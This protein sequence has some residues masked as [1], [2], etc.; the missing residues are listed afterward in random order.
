MTDANSLL[1]LVGLRLIDFKSFVDERVELEAPLTFL[2][3]GN[4]S[5]KSNFLDAL[6]FLK[7]VAIGLPVE[8]VLAGSSAVNWPGLRGGIEEAAR[9]GRPE[10]SIESRWELP[11]GRQLEHRITCRV[12][13][14]VEIP[15]E[16]LWIVGD[17]VPLFQ[18]TTAIEAPQALYQLNARWAKPELAG[19]LHLGRQSSLAQYIHPDI[20][21]S[22]SVLLSMSL[23]TAMLHIRFLDFDVSKMRTYNSLK[24]REIGA[25][26]S[27]LS[28][29][30]YHLCEVADQ[31]QDLVD[32]LS[33]LCSPRI[34]GVEFIEVPQ[35]RDVLLYLVEEDGT[36]VSVKSLSDGT[37][38]FL[39]LLVTLKTASHGEFIL[40]EEPETGLHPARAG[41]LTQ[42]LDAVASDRR[43]HVIATTHSPLVL[44]A[45]DA[46]DS[47]ALSRAIV[48]GRRWEAPGTVMRRLGDL[49]NFQELSTRR[50]VDHLF[51]TEWL[52]RSL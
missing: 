27:N 26:G 31:R 46:E 23:R 41:L 51:T 28:A 22:E 38:R 12:S 7:G 20:Y 18:R 42:M 37:L 13:P 24:V 44:L 40:L 14:R 45:L 29:V 4:A 11:D 15:Q 49:P 33:E 19:A 39:A 9:S 21:D 16:S 10:F 30:A 1:R 32:W 8:D 36:R 47:R 2:V 43:C 52:E 50:G 3:G 48:F 35:I 6:R 25:D 17:E 34:S 5:G